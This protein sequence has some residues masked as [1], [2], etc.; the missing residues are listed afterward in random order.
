MTW[1]RVLKSR[2]VALFR[3]TRL[4]RQLDEELNSHLE[5]LVEGNVRNGMPPDEAR[6]AA[7]RSFGGVEQAKEGYRERSARQREIGVRLAIGSSRWRLVRQ[8]L[9]ETL[10]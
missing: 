8:I 7:L 3:K 1:L 9:H 6:Y 4:E 2:L 5:M 10:L